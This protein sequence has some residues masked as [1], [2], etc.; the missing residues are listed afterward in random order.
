[1]P[2]SPPTDLRQPA[3]TPADH[4]AWAWMSQALEDRRAVMRW[5]DGQSLQGYAGGLLAELSTCAPGSLGLISWVRLVDQP[6][7]PEDLLARLKSCAQAMTEGGLLM[8]ADLGPTSLASLAQSVEPQSAEGLELAAWRAGRLDLH[9]LGDALS[10]AGLAEPVM[11]S[12]S[13]ALTYR[14]EQTALDDLQALGLFLDQPAQAWS[15]AVSGLRA[16]DGLIRLTLE[17]VIGHA[18]RM[19]SRKPKLDPQT[20]TPIRFARRT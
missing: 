3:I 15:R 12:E 10:A 17:V 13:L 11:E 5:P 4:P 9:D 14:S 16:P 2:P 1:M 18:W 20:P 8:A 6:L 19:P 7:R